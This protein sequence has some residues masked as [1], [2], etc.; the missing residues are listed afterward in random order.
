MPELRVRHQA[1]KE[2]KQTIDNMHSI[3]CLEDAGHWAQRVQHP[4]S[5][6]S[7]EYVVAT[8]G[9]LTPRQVKAVAEGCEMD[10]VL[11][12]PLSVEQVPGLR[13]RLRIVVGEGR[14]REVCNMNIAC[15]VLLCCACLLACC[16]GPR[17]LW[18]TWSSGGGYVVGNA[19]VCDSGA[20]LFSS[21]QPLV[22]ADLASL[23]HQHDD[24]P[25]CR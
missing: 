3:N 18:V 10:G 24:S 20:G 11:V 8:S 22:A 5:G 19:R 16:G 25:Q 4:S 14:N 17:S 7:K 15:N 2:H 21:S 12:Q 23:V 1:H 6:I 9:L 13:D